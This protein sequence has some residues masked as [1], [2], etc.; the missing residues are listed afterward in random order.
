MVE[1]IK[2]LIE[3]VER[4]EYTTNSYLIALNQLRGQLKTVAIKASTGSRSAHSKLKTLLIKCKLIKTRYNEKTL[5]I[6]KLNEKINMLE[7]NEM[8]F[9]VEDVMG[10][11][12]ALNDSTGMELKIDRLNPLFSNVKFLRVLRTQL[13]THE[14]YEKCA[15]LQKRI[16]TLK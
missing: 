9:T 2:V 13:E 7:L 16:E 14:I 6:D 1:S 15:L 12:K 3:E 10:F 5:L 4:L 8:T 11:E